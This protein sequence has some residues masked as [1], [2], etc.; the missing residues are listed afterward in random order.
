MFVCV[1]MESKFKKDRIQTYTMGKKLN[2]YRVLNHTKLLGDP[3]LRGWFDHLL[4]R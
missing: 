1:A 2:K 3:P 4:I